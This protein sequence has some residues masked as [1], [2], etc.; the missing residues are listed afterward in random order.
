[1][2]K[3]Y[4]VSK[5][6]MD[7]F[8]FPKGFQLMNLPKTDELVYG[9]RLTIH[10]HPV[11]IRVYSSIE[12]SEARPCGEDAIRVSAYTMI[13]G[14]IVQIGS[15]HKV[16]RIKTWAKN[17][18][19]AIAA[20]VEDWKACPA[21]NHPMVLR[22]GAY[23]EF[24]GCSAF[25]ITGCN[26]K[27]SPNQQVESNPEPPVSSKPTTVATPKAHG[28]F[29]IADEHISDQQKAAERVFVET[30]KHMVLPSRAGGGKTTMLKHLASFRKEGQSIA[31]LAFNKKNAEEGKKKLPREVASMTTHSFCSRMLRDYGI[32]MP[33]RADSSKNRKVLEEVYPAMNNKD[34]KRIRKS[35][36]KLIGLAKNFACR[37]GDK[38]AITEVMNKYNF[39][40]ENKAEEL[41]VVEIVDQVLTLS[42]P[43]KKFGSIYDFDDMIW[44]PVVL[45]MKPTFYD[46]VLLDEVQDFNACQI[47]LVSRMM[48]K[49][50]RLVAVGDPYQAVYRFRG[51]DSDAFDKVQETLNSGTRGCT[52]VLLPTN[53][54]CSKS[55]IRWVRENSVVHDIEACD[56]APEGLVDESMSYNQI[57][58][59]LVEEFGKRS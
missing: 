13:Q 26:G 4:P 46:V 24:W 15:T 19:S 43:G 41:T 23:G 22:N 51:A 1:M 7:D 57:L 3:F 18:E 38:D 30:D 42:V 40:L 47:E 55:V 16:L 25:K 5:Q 10:N 31:Y 12:G 35:A 6:E 8:L 20:V 50:S 29:R 11:S 17:L 28:G 36:F 53:Y 56:N 44:W 37:P 45:D 32:S 54:R 48:E 33:E 2:S 9:K 49:G 39:E 14:E 27:N 58:D 52:V 59:L 34:R 21:C